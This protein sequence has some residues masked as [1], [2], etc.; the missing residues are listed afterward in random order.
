MAEL[1]NNLPL[2]G[3]QVFMKSYEV[4]KLRHRHYQVCKNSIRLL[5]C[6]MLAWRDI[7]F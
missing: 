3:A 6:L 1:C 4:L 7:F 5:V 2:H